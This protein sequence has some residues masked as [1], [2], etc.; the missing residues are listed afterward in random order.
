MSQAGPLNVEAIPQVATIYDGNTGSATP[1]GNVLNIVGTGD[2][3]TSASGNTVTIALTSTGAIETVTGNTG[4]PVAP[5]ANNIDILGNFTSAGGGS[6]CS[7]SGSGSTLLVNVQLSEAAGSSSANN[8]GVCSFSTA[9]FSVDANGYVT[10]SGTD[11][12]QTITGNTGGA[13][14]PSA[15]NFNIVGTG[16]VTVAGTANTETI[17]LTG[18]TNH[19]VLV[20]AG[21]ATITKI[22][23]SAS[24]GQILQNNAAADPSY[25]TATYPSMTTI[26][27]ILYSS[28]ANIVGGL[29][30]ANQGVLTTGTTGIP[31]ITAI[32][33]NGQLIIGSTAGAPA[34]A[35][36]SAGTGISITNGANS[37]TIAATGSEMTWTD[38]AISFAAAVGNG[39]FITANATAT[40]PAG[41][42]GNVIA[43]AVDAAATTL[44]VQAA[45]GQIIRI[46]S[47][48]SAATGTAANNARGDSVTFVYR[49][50]DTAWI[51]TSIIGTWTVT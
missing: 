38:E 36:L 26:N 11:A 5:V 2:V 19:A 28:S 3:Q 44:T 4:S 29:A 15:G 13:E 31:V 39:Y 16:S 17:Q 18:L 14:S 7:T 25:S 22:G 12:I 47:A 23:P 45:A 27:Q 1:L 10:L 6:P 8:A 32:A 21:S 34:A 35:T 40:M 46:G 24:T 51:A 43:F 33:T 20:G 49:S 30:T 48:V 9:N 42:Q 37:I 41:S 50:S